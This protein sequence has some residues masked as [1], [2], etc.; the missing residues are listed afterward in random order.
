MSVNKY[1]LKIKNIVDLL[2]LVGYFLSTQDHIDAIFE[3]ISFGY[4]IFVVS[5]TSY[6]EPYS[7]EEIESL[8]LAHEAIIDKHVKRLDSGV[9]AVANVIT[10]SGF[11]NQN[12]S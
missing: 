5:I 12:Q 6:S 2:A 9:S 4:D 8:L 11:G 1:L 7:I 3:G 10:R